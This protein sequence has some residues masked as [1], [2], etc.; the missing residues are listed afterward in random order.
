MVFSLREMPCS[1]VMAELC[2]FS[3]AIWMVSLYSLPA[4]SLYSYPGL[5]AGS[6]CQPL[7]TIDPSPLHIYSVWAHQDSILFSDWVSGTI[8][9]ASISNGVQKVL[10]DGLM[11]PTQMFIQ[12][13]FP[14]GNPC[15]AELFCIQPAITQL[16]I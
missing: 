5:G 15:L 6:D 9:S 11:R 1:L 8:T 14:E 13:T 7:N 2:E 12:Y 4:L 16:C 10:V 3:P